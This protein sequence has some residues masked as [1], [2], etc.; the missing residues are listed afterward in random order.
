MQLPPKAKK[1]T[2]LP[3]QERLDAILQAARECF[4]REGYENAKMADIAKQIGVVEGTVFHYFNSKRALMLRVMEDFHHQINDEV[5]EGLKGVI[6]ARN[7]LQYIVEFH[8]GVLATNPKLCGVILRESRK[9]DDKYS[10]DIREQHR[11]YTRALMGVLEEGIAS[12]EFRSDTSAPVI[13]NAIFGGM[14]H[15]L[16]QLLS[17]GHA[18]DVPLITRQL[19]EMVCDGICNRAPPEGAVAS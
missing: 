17:E 14:E 4:E 19:T 11:I 6:G 15:A 13:R 1:T 10:R 2:R 12:G 8:L 3:K 16:W 18:I 5:R 7:R 9:L